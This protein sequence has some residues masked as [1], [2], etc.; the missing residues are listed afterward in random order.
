LLQRPPPAALLI[1][2]LGIPGAI[3]K[4]SFYCLYSFFIFFSIFDG[5]EFTLP[6][7]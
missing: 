2:L 5:I 6:L 1:S 4:L 3:P 7:L